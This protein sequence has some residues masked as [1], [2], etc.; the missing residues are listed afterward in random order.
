MYWK[1]DTSD[2]L[3]INFKIEQP[4]KFG[5]LKLCKLNSVKLFTELS[6]CDVWQ[7]VFEEKSEKIICLSVFVVPLKSDTL[8]EIDK[9]AIAKQ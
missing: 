9:T 8:M 4:P 6:E 7:I 2:K 1:Y 5:F 3:L